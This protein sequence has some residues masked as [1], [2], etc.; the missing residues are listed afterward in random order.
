MPLKKRRKHRLPIMEVNIV[1]MMDMITTLLF[2][3][4]LMGFSHYFI[5]PA[6]PLKASDRAKELDKPIFTLSVTAKAQKEVLILLGP[7]K[8]LG[9]QYLNELNQFLNKEFQGDEDIGFLKILKENEWG[10][11]KNKIREILKIIKRS[12]PNE[13]QV[14]VAFADKIKYQQ[15]ID[16]ISWVRGEEVKLKQSLR[17]IME[18]NMG[19]KTDL[20]PEIILS[21]WK[22][23]IK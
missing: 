9:A 18:E 3:L 15:M 5:L 22:E 8:G 13:K 14:V 7:I 10:L 11:Y 6:N 17:I 4:I 19:N 21:E 1:T 23:S 20:F 12:F 16:L 2:F